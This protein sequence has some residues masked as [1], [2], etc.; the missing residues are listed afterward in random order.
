M[1]GFIVVVCRLEIDS[2]FLKRQ[3]KIEYP[4][5]QLIFILYKRE[6]SFWH[7]I[8]FCVGRIQYPFPPVPHFGLISSRPKKSALNTISL[9]LIQN[10]NNELNRND[11][12]SL[13]NNK[14]F[15][16]SLLYE[17]AKY[18][19]SCNYEKKNILLLEIIMLSVLNLN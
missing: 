10:C 7:V 5:R 12:E 14:Y 9:S 4:F 3:H 16:H 15:P 13:A 17:A 1:F 6:P 19:Y 11:R 8:T 18:I 2:H